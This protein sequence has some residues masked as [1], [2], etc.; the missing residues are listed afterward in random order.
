MRRGIGGWGAALAFA[1]ALAL[2]SAAAAA[3]GPAGP[4]GSAAT[5]RAR[6]SAKALPPAEA[7]RLRAALR[8]AVAAVP[9]PANPYRLSSEYDENHV[10]PPPAARRPG[11][12]VA[13]RYYEVPDSTPLEALPIR[14]PG[15]V[16]PV[17]VTVSV[18]ADI[19]LPNLTSIASDTSRVVLDG[20]EAAR[21][22]AVPPR[23]LEGRIAMMNA[24]EAEYR[25]GAF[26]VLV[27][28]S[29]AEAAMRSVTELKETAALAGVMPRPPRRPGDVRWISVRVHGP[30]AV[31]ERVARGIDV[32]ALRK[33]LAP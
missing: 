21:V 5:P 1:G 15:L 14:N 13:E 17:E 8:A 31:V 27:A 26:Y 11:V 7:K 29:A 16:G 2:V 19:V 3:P 18:N 28:D 22:D 23:V 25:L 4:A 30:L 20:A 9:A 24:D 6:P 12:A 10:L 33:L 32:R